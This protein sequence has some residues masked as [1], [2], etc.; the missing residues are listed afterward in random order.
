MQV[1]EKVLEPNP[2]RDE[3]ARLLYRALRPESKE[4]DIRSELRHG[5]I[6]ELAILSEP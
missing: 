4:F 3:S 6:A 2:C 5:K 1:G